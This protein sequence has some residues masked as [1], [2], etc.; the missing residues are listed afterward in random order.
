MYTITQYY[1]FELLSTI[2][3]WNSNCRVIFFGNVHEL[4]IIKSCG[5]SGKPK[6]YK[7]VRFKC[8]TLQVVAVLNENRIW[9]R[10]FFSAYTDGKTQC[11]IC[12]TV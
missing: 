4:Y 6:A 12:R 10:I 5:P 7:H 9:T 11:D 1:I 3:R 2:R 8:I